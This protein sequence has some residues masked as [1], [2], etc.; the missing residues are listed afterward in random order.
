MRVRVYKDCSLLVDTDT[1][2]QIIKA[3][4]AGVLKFLNDTTSGSGKVLVR[5]DA[6]E[7]TKWQVSI[8]APNTDD[9][10]SVVKP[11]P[12]YGTYTG[13]TGCASEANFAIERSHTLTGVGIT[14]F[15]LFVGS[16][17]VKASVHYQG[18]L[19][20]STN[21]FVTG[22]ASLA[23]TFLPKNNDAQIV[24][25]IETQKASTDWR[26][27][28]YCPAQDGS[29]E[30]KAKYHGGGIPTDC[31]SIGQPLDPEF[32]RKSTGADITDTWFD[33]N[34]QP[35]GKVYIPYTITAEN[36]VQILVYQ[37]EKLKT[38]IAPTIG[39]GRFSFSFDH[40]KGTSIRVRVVGTCCPEWEYRFLCPLPLPMIYVGDVSVTRGEA[41]T[42][43]PM[44]FPIKLSHMYDEPITFN[45]SLASVSAISSPDC[46][47]HDEPQF[48]VITDPS[49]SPEDLQ[50]WGRT[51]GNTYFPPFSSSWGPVN[52]WS[53]DTVNHAL[54]VS[55][56]GDSF[57]SV[58]ST[59]KADRFTYEVTLGSGAGD[60]DSAGMVIAFANVNGQLHY[61]VAVRSGGNEKIN[62]ATVVGFKSGYTYYFLW[63][64]GGVVQKVL[65][66]ANIGGGGDWKG[67]FTRIK[68]QRDGNVFQVWCSPWNSTV[69]AD[70]SHFTYDISTDPAMLAIFGGPCEF[71]VF[72]WSLSGVYYKDFNINVLT[73]PAG[74]ENKPPV[75]DFKQLADGVQSLTIAA[76]SE[77]AQ[78]CIDVCGSD[79]YIPP[80][81]VSITLSNVK[82]A[83]IGDGYAVGTIFGKA[84]ECNQNTQ[85][86]VY[87]AGQ[88]TVVKHGARNMYV[89]MLS[90]YAGFEAVMD[91]HLNIPA[92]GVYT[93]IL[94]GLSNAELYI[95]CDLVL[96][97][98]E[99]H[100]TATAKD[101][102]VAAGSRYLY[103]KYGNANA[104]RSAS[105]AALAVLNAKGNLVYASN[106]TDWRA[107]VGEAGV[108]PTCEQFASTC[109]VSPTISVIASSAGNDTNI[110]YPTAVR[111]Q[112]S[113]HGDTAPGNTFYTLE[114]KM[115]FPVSGTYTFIGTGDDNYWFYVD[116]V[117]SN[118]PTGGDWAQVY[119]NTID[120]TAGEH[121]VT[122][123]YKNLPDNTPGWVKFVLL[124][125]SGNL[126]YAS[127]PTGWL[128]AKG[129]LSQLGVPLVV[130]PNGDPAISAL[131]AMDPNF[132]PLMATFGPHY[133]WFTSELHFTFTK[134]DT[135]T[136]VASADD[137]SEVY[138]GCQFVVATTSYNNVF[139]T[140]FAAS[141]G[142]TNIVVRCY[143]TKGDHWF[144]FI[145]KDS[146]GNIVYSTNTAGWKSRNSDVDWTGLSR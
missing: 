92:D 10:F 57:V 60:D 3:G 105:Y 91:M 104:T 24:V 115:T 139:E 101:Y 12:C 87:D 37:N 102:W 144:G 23:W 64:Q 88:S 63:L 25:R 100:A 67:K 39:S 50:S 65:G 48:N 44:C 61:L 134:D 55:S 45:Y 21:G 47:Q 141:A 135:Y 113:A 9:E 73:V 15:D 26:Y 84:A 116:C 2:P 17:P 35:D 110:G 32:R 108:K 41:G 30:F 118:G 97:N 70:S 146:D 40:K 124:D 79:R 74:M 132:T 31:A 140:Q 82:N 99:P 81:T 126:F 89:S 46:V 86:A 69:Y 54:R 103:I 72:A 51:I 38:G 77:T 83:G 138:I 19:L 112:S 130:F 14:H 119:K 122:L 142:E 136:I 22:S 59:G 109:S 121:Q 127:N 43:T 93:F 96:T 120:V 1:Q 95:D 33:L 53:V 128:S 111:I 11:A 68:A 6:A 80:R 123:M 107:K 62:D 106:A 75:S 7:T 117:Q 131:R 34:G 5:V 78:V 71:G 94:H 114:Q 29:L 13:R 52:I 28:V 58:V 137:Q 20:A 90:A 36:P 27:A 42:L 49:S 66:Y 8:S 125:P 133:S 98:N 129:D 85:V 76:C 145:I 16:E 18:A 56:G 143:N 4:S